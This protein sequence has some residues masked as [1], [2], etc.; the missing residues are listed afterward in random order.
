MFENFGKQLRKLRTAKGL[1]QAELGRQINCNAAAIKK[2]ESGTML[3]S[4]ETAANLTVQLEV[5]PDELFDCENC[6]RIPTA[7]L[8]DKQK[9][10]IRHLVKIFK[11]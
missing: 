2:F 8:T 9:E 7:G 5:S 4:L 10:F 1:T 11:D 6:S 3:P